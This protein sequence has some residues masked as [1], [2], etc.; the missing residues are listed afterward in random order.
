MSCEAKQVLLLVC[1]A[2]RQSKYDSAMLRLV[3]ELKH[4]FKLLSRL[5]VILL[6]SIH[7]PG[8]DGNVRLGPQMTRCT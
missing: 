4:R 8:L 1:S 3:G 5:I 6:M 2:W 7:L